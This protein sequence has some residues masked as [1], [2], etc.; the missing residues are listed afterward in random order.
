MRS[1]LA[2]AVFSAR[3]SCGLTQQDL[4]RRLGLRGRA[5]YRWENDLSL[6]NAHH[7]R[8]LVTAIQAVNP[9]LAA[10]LASALAQRGQP[11]LL[12]P[13]P[14]P[15]AAREVLERAVFAAADELD[16]SPRR[17][18]GALVRLLRR[19]RAGDVTLDAALAELERWIAEAAE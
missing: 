3:R 8:A 9:V 12:P 7:R 10:Q 13:G 17:T 15:A 18:R 4:G 14:P 11:P 2:Q 5:I 6:P 1:T 19:L 16:L